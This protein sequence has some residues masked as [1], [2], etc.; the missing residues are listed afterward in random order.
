MIEKTEKEVVANIQPRPRKKLEPLNINSSLPAISRRNNVFT[1]KSE[2]LNG[3]LVF[4]EDQESIESES[5]YD[6][7]NPHDTY[8]DEKS[9]FSSELKDSINSLEEQESD[10]AQEKAKMLGQQRTSFFFMGPEKL[11]TLKGSEAK[12]EEENERRKRQPIEKNNR[13]LIN[14]EGRF[15]NLWDTSNLILIVLFIL[16]KLYTSVLLPFKIGFITETYFV[17]DIADRIVDFFFF[18]DLIFTFFTPVYIDFDFVKSHWKIAKNY[19][20]SIWFYLDFV[21]VFPF[22]LFVPSSANFITLAKMLKLPRL[23]RFVRFFE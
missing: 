7:N 15:K 11:K 23:Y 18:L 6:I 5:S 22:E 14:T 12:V 20:G 9:S 10:R 2:L 17:W 4:P 3:G 13:F 8:E 1:K 21:S 16:Y 19:L